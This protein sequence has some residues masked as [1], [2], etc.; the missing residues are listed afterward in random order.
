M[1]L[2]RGIHSQRQSQGEKR[3]LRVSREH[4]NLHLPVATH[5]EKSKPQLHLSVLPS[6]KLR[7]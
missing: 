2:I 6:E 3:F 1:G 5:G 7:A 4:S